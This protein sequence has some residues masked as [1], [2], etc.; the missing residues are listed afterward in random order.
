MSVLFK[1]HNNDDD[2]DTSYGYFYAIKDFIYLQDLYLRRTLVNI[3][4]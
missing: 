2:E 4:R 1:R 3:E